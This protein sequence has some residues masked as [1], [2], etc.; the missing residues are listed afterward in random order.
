[1]SADGA[2]RAPRQ[3]TES[4]QERNLALRLLRSLL[5]P[6]LA[7]LA[8][9]AV[10]AL[11]MI[12]SDAETLRA[13]ASFFRNPGRALDLSWDLA[14]EAYSALF[15][16][17][18]GSANAISETI[19]ASTPLIFAGLAVALA[20]K[21]GLFN[22]GAEGQLLVGAV[23]AAFVG[24]TFT[25]LPGP[26]LL[27]MALAGG[28][29]AGGLWGF[30]PG[31]LKAKTGAHEVIVTIMMNYVAFRLVDYLLNTETFRRTGRTDPI[32]KAVGEGARLPKIFGQDY[33]IHLGIVLALVAAYGIWWLLSR[34][35]I[36]FTIRSVGANPN[37]ARYAGMS[38]GGAFMLSM[39]MAGGLA[40]LGGASQLLGIQ[41]SVF[42]G[43]SSG[44]G[45]DAIALALLGRTNPFG[46][47][48]AALLFGVLRSGAIGMQAATSV[49]VD[50]IVVIQALVIV[51]MAAPDL[52]R[53]MFR[54]REERMPEEGTLSAGW[55]G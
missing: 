35:T 9:L 26:L 33:R 3:G 1:M 50:I 23:G 19:V 32:T 11:V 48:L 43:F 22:I 45:F 29:V 24:F 6:V 20:F 7:L 18:L 36:G 16:A 14:Y 13:W 31:F 10:G 21:A 41:Y 44:Y 49:P 54:V 28:A 37:A 42:P 38:V 5:V 51:F 4:L 8:G 55:G 2:V 30:V 40:G 53:E 52:V 34:S 12:F 15:Q 47:V 17:S 25:D 27:P 39:A 46:V